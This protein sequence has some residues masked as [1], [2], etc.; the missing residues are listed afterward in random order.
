M[1]FRG[2]VKITINEMEIF[3]EGYEAKKLVHGIGVAVNLRITNPDGELEPGNR[4]VELKYRDTNH[5]YAPFLPYYVRLYVY[6]Q[7]DE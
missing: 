3:P 1:Y 5:S 6:S 2:T 7:I 4:K